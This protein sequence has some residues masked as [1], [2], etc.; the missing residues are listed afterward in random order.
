M[1]G[2]SP[3]APEESREAYRRPRILSALARR[4]MGAATALLVFLAA[5]S[6]AA[7]AYEAHGSG[8]SGALP[9]I[10]RLLRRFDMT[11]LAG[12][13][14]LLVFRGAAAIDADHRDG[15]LPAFFAAGGSRAGSGTAFVLVAVI[16][17]AAVFVAAAL[18]FAATVAAVAGSTELL[19]V[20]PR[21][22]G[23]GLLVLGTWA[24]CVVAVGMTVRRASA[25]VGI[26]AA[27]AVVPS[28]LLLRLAFT[29]GAAPLWA[30][31]VQL[32]SPLLVLPADTANSVRALIYIGL[33]GGIA[34]MLSHRY[35]G[36]GQ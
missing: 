12:A 9:L 31:Q 17:P 5:A 27:L 28:F 32:L 22:I 35:A 16:G 4:E 15:W 8:S 23:R 19:Q 26:V 20:L 18:T 11:A 3:A 6:A 10:D 33:V 24:V 2:R 25:T 34:A 7:A 21:T 36:R 29:E 1:S 14:M 30:L 13:V